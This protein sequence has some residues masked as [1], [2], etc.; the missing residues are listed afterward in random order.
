MATVGK[1][2]VSGNTMNPTY[3][4]VIAIVDDAP[5]ND[6]VAWQKAHHKA[7]GPWVNFQVKGCRADSWIPLD[8][9]TH[10]HFETWEEMYKAFQSRR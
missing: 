1:V 7:T 9:F 8:I 3:S 5:D 2:Y 10:N 6:S 4:T